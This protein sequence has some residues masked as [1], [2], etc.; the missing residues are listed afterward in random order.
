MPR[1]RALVRCFVDNGLRN[2][3][4]VFNYDGPP[5]RYL[6]PVDPPAEVKPA[7]SEATPQAEPKKPR[8]PYVFKAR[9]TPISDGSA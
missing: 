2:E 5:L 6:E 9:R 8:K 4:D 3:G 7:P 1:Y